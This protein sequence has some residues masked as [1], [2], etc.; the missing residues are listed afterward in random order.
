MNTTHGK[1][2]ILGTVMAI[3]SMAGQASTLSGETSVP[4]S[5]AELSSIGFEAQARTSCGFNNRGVQLLWNETNGIAPDFFP[6]AKGHW[7]PLSHPQAPILSV[8]HPAEWY[9][10]LMPQLDLGIQIGAPDN[11][12]VFQQFNKNTDP[13]RTSRDVVNYGINSLL[14]QL[15]QNPSWNILCVQQDV[16]TYPVRLSTTTIVATNGESIIVA[17]AKLYTDPN[18]P[19]GIGMFIGGAGSVDEF[20]SLTENVFLPLLYINKPRNNGSCVRG[21]DSDLDGIDDCDD[22][23][24]NDPNRR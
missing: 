7:I 9:G 11:R 23:F 3:T 8:W 18:L 13:A 5:P 16:Q 15:G 14:S 6:V 20:T 10:M 17:S 4:M 24:P 22:N 1:G 2:M 12:A 19:Q 21:T